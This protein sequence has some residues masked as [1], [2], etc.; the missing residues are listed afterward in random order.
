MKV[1]ETSQDLS[2][3]AQKC[4]NSDIILIPI[5][6][7]HSRHPRLSSIIGIYIFTLNNMQNYYISVNHEEAIL[8]F[9]IEAIVDI[10]STTKV[11]SYLITYYLLIMLFAA[12]PFHI[13]QVE[14]KLILN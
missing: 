6:S 11:L 8:N 1:I 9:D 2:E 14:T 3:L 4:N 10:I 13:F 7:D 12:I 5:L